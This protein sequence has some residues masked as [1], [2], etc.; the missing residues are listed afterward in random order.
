MEKVNI[1]LLKF[2]P[3]LATVWDELENKVS[4]IA[5][6]LADQPEGLK[7]R[8]LPFQREG[9]SWMRK[10]ENGLV[11]FPHYACVLFAW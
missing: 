2:H 4:V 1:E 9:L 5:P 8:L 6:E 7:L 11:C 3:E 10:Q